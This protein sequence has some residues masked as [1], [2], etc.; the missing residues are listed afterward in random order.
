MADSDEKLADARTQLAALE[1]QLSQGTA[2]QGGLPTVHEA[3]NKV[4]RDVQ[5]VSK[6]SRNSQQ[7][8]NFRGIDA[9]MN[10]VGP[11]LREHGVI[12]VPDVYDID[13]ERYTTKSGGQMVSRVVKMQYTVYGPAG[14]NFSGVVYGEAADSGDKGTTKAESVALRTFLLQ[15]LMLPTDEPDPDASSHERAAAPAPAGNAS[16]QEARDKLRALAEEKGWDVNN[17]ANEFS[18]HNNGKS[19]RDAT[20]DEVVAYT[21]LLVS[22][23]VKV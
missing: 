16:S 11:V 19:L 18:K 17:V 12:V 3:W 10:A 8:F 5:H 1:A 21:N 15:A 20:G 13:S 7:G 9:V 14:D 4:M 22:G 6:D 2:I 23:A